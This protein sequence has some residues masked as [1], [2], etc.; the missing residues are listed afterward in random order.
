MWW[1]SVPPS[2]FHLPRAT[3]RPLREKCISRTRSRLRL[4]RLCGWVSFGS[5]VCTTSIPRRF[6]KRCFGVLW[7]RLWWA[8]RRRWCFSSSCLQTWRPK[9]FLRSIR[10]LWAR[11]VAVSRFALLRLANRGKKARAVIVGEGQTADALAEE[12]RANPFRYPFTVVAVV[13]PKEARRVLPALSQE[14][15]IEWLIV[16]TDHPSAAQDIGP[17]LV[18]ATEH[19]ARPV[20]LLAMYEHIFDRVPLTTAYPI[21]LDHLL[22]SSARWYEPVKRAF[23]IVFALVALAVV[24]LLTP[25]VWLAYRLEGI[26]G[27][28]WYIHNRVGKGMRS[29]RAVKF[30]TLTRL[31]PEGQ[32]LDEA[33][34]P[35]TKVGKVL[36][37]LSLD[38]LPQAINVLKGEMSFIGPRADALGVAKRLVAELPL[39]PLRYLVQPGITGW[40]QT[41]QRY[42]EG[43]IS[44]Q[45]VAESAERLAYDL[46]YIAH[47]GWWADVSGAV[48]DR[49][50]ASR[51]S[52]CF[53]LASWERAPLRPRKGVCEG[54][55]KVWRRQPQHGP[56]VLPASPRSR[57]L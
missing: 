36:R 52:G 15:A 42:P 55:V 43:K 30:R 48:S 11:G 56:R 41:H 8:L 9:P 51:A 45:N 14:G 40:A 39:Y 50:H 6:F 20:S 4:W 49:A 34:N 29:F 16:Q 57:P 25:L 1:C 7:A 46:Y 35:P 17:L 23:D 18:W 12:V 3:W 22:Q 13:P 27:G 54:F 2:G 28:V 37:A 44:P 24:A 38:E 31:D 26:E 32:L 53:P 33:P 47:Y 5:L 10:S 21:L 19:G